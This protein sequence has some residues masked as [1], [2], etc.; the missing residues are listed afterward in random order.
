MGGVE[1]EGEMEPS[2]AKEQHAQHSGKAS[3]W[4]DG[5]DGLERNEN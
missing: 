1:A 2:R 3:F 5:Y 4:A